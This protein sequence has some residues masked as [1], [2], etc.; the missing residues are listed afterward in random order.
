MCVY[1]L[2]TLKAHHVNNYSLQ[3]IYKILNTTPPSQ[4]KL[5]DSYFML[6]LCLDSCATQHNNKS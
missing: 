6:H 1:L 3:W 4:Q 2:V 5:L